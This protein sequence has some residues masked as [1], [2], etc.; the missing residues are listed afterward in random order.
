MPANFR[1][2]TTN[3]LRKILLQKPEPFRACPP[4]KI[5]RFV[6]IVLI[7][8]LCFVPGNLPNLVSINEIIADINNRGSEIILPKSWP[9]K[10][11]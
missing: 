9:A 5:K 6:S 11:A 3:I 7:L 4:V 1:S 10:D 8:H 2:Q